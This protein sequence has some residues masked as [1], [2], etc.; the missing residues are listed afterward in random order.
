MTAYEMSKLEFKDE[1][2]GGRNFEK[3]SVKIPG[4]EEGMVFSLYPERI[5]KWGPKA[6]HLI[7]KVLGPSKFSE[8]YSFLHV[9][10]KLKGYVHS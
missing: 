9:I 2:D 7:L 4:E 5:M 1:S 3:V 8:H 6:Y 10:I